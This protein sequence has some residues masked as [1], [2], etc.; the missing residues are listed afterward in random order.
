M[1]S[2]QQDVAVKDRK[3]NRAGDGARTSYVSSRFSA[4]EIVHR[5]NWPIEA[6]CD[7]LTLTD[8]NWPTELENNRDGR[9]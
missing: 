5:R 1:K 8:D 6:V 4:A 3:D 7:G 2:T 9:F